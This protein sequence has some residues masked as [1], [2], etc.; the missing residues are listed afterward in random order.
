ML[1][2]SL[3]RLLEESESPTSGLPAEML[4]P[5]AQ[6]LYALSNA[7]PTNLFIAL[8]ASTLNIEAKSS[9]AKELIQRT[10]DLSAAIEPSLRAQTQS[11][12]LTPASLVQQIIAAMEMNDWQKARNQMMLWFNVLNATDLVKTDRRLAT[13]HPLDRLSFDALRRLSA[14]VAANQPIQSA[15]QPIEFTQTVINEQHT[16]GATGF[17]SVIDVDLELD[18]DVIA[19]VVSGQTTQATIWRN[20]LPKG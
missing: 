19:F 14:I 8:R 15:K 17:S 16:S 3:S 1:G 7:E 5:A 13:P 2:G 4:Q 6:S 10:L 11:V 12:G 9:A 20:D 18:S